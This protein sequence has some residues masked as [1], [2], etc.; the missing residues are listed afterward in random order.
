MTLLVVFVEVLSVFRC[1]LGTE[2]E[3]R[4]IDIN[5][6]IWMSS[7]SVLDHEILSAGRI[8]A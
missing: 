8:A 2:N 3:T 5:F 7:M 4:A 1:L 6:L